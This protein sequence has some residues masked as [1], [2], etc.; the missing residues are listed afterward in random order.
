ML[1]R[2]ILDDR[3]YLLLNGFACHVETFIQVQRPLTAIFPPNATYN[4]CVHKERFCIPIYLFPD[5]MPNTR[6]GGQGLSK[7]LICFSASLYYGGLVFDACDRLV[8]M[9][10]VEAPTKK[11]I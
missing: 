1:H 11:D 10:F 4:P 5:F 7:S 9:Q 6:T 2:V 3:L 8:G